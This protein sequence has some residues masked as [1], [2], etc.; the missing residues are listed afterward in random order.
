MEVATSPPSRLRPKL[1]SNPCGRTKV[2]RSTLS[3]RKIPIAGGGRPRIA[4]NDYEDDGNDT[5]ECPRRN[6]RG[7]SPSSTPDTEISKASSLFSS[8]G[9]GY[10]S[11]D[12]EGETAF[13]PS[14][15]T[16]SQRKGNQTRSRRSMS[17]LPPSEALTE[18]EKAV[19]GL[20]LDTNSEREED[21][22]TKQKRNFQDSRTVDTLIRDHLLRFMVHVPGAKPDP[23]GGVY[24]MRLSCWRDYINIG[25]T[26]KFEDRMK[27]KCDSI[28]QLAGEYKVN[29]EPVPRH[30]GWEKLMH[31]ELSPVAYYFKCPHCT[32][33]KGKIARHREMFKADFD[34]VVE[35]HDRWFAW[36]RLE[37][38]NNH[39]FLKREWYHRLH[40]LFESYS[41]G[42]AK[43]WDFKKSK[44]RWDKFTKPFRG[45]PKT[46]NGAGCKS[47]DD[48]EMLYLN[49]S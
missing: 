6:V 35:I 46:W 29:S 12:S 49:P 31:I 16:P 48:Y 40:R 36:F 4:Y 26:E 27:S 22:Y 24:V 41:K 18:L 5:E 39:G 47:C 17:P 25:R 1:G 42:V 20:A 2:P 37:P 9:G 23:Q 21:V 13:D 19:E 44:E 28:S 14:S 10:S 7:G 43:E 34:E 38:Y 30:R 45:N 33:K 15:P 8:A 3:A 11:P 32:A